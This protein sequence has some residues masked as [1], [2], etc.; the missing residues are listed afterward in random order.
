MT[1]KATV[2]GS[3]PEIIRNETGLYQGNL[4]QYFSVVFLKAQNCNC[5]YHN[6]RHMFH[7]LWLCY[8]ACLFYQEQLTPRQKRNLLVAA[9]FHDF[10]HS[11]MAGD[12]DLNIE[13]AIRAF[14]RHLVTEDVEATPDIV[15]LIKATQYPY[16]VPTNQLSLS[17]KIIR[18]ADISQALSVAWVQ[19]VIFGLAAEWR[20]QPIEV[21][22][23]Q[24]SFLSQLSF[25]TDWAQQLFPP[26]LIELK[27]EEA[28][29]LLQLLEQPAA[30]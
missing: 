11:G 15:E 28:K 12:D 22:K 27:I 16:T 25:A 26:S 5:P 1:T 8:D 7:V 19:Q 9:L 21:L 3:I 17:G 14:E 18:D 10:N 6:F 13:R 4:I 2:Q 24:G 23:A 20:T 29:A 30:A